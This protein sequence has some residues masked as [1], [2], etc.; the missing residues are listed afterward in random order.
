MVRSGH[1]Y[2]VANGKVYDT[3][4]VLRAI[5]RDPLDHKLLE[6]RK[7]SDFAKESRPPFN[8]DRRA[9]E[10]D[11]DSI[12]KFDVYQAGKRIGLIACGDDNIQIFFDDDNIQLVVRSSAIGEFLVSF[13]RCGVCVGM[14][15]LI[16]S[17]FLGVS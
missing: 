8:V 15:V 5:L 10:L 7:V 14:F 12:D 6:I 11:E 3:T 16:V 17:Y 1:C 9:N 13:S 2:A 4:T